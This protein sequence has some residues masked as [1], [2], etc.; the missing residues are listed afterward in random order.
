MANLALAALVALATVG[1]SH[2]IVPSTYYRTFSRAHPVLQ[3]VKPGDSIVHEDAR[4]RRGRR[5]GRHPERAVQPPERAVLRRGGRA[6]RR[7]GGQDHDAEDEPQ[8][9]LVG[10]PLGPVLAHARGRRERLFERSTS[11]T[12]SARGGRTLVPWDIDLAKQT[13]KLREP[14]SAKLPMEFPARPM[15]GCIGV[16]P[17]G[18]F[19]PTSGPSGAYGGN[20]DY[21]KIGQGATV[22]LPVYHPGALLFVG[23]GHALQAD[24]EPTGTGIETSM[25]VEFTVE[26]KKGAAPAGP[27]V[28]TARRPDL[29]R[30]AA[31]VRQRPRQRPQ[32]G[33]VRHGQVAHQGLRPRTLG[34]PP[35]HRLSGQVR[36]RDRRRL[37]GPAG[38]EGR[39]PRAEPLRPPS[40][41]SRR[42][43]PK[44]EPKPIAEKTAKL[45]KVDGFL[46]L[47]W[48]E[49]TGKVLMEIPRFDREFLYQVTLDDRRGLEPDRAR[50]GPARLDQGRRFPEGRA[51]GL[52][53]GAQLSLPR[54]QR[55]PRRA[56]V[57]RAVVREVGPLG[58]QGR[59]RGGRPGPGQRHRL[60]RPRRPRRRRPPDPDQA[61]QV[62]GGRLA[63]R[64][65][66]ARP[67]G[68][69]RR[70][71][72]SRRP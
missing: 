51:E 39:P 5:E 23:D 42:P 38:P 69:S 64:P 71:P 62:Q 6:W 66:P 29:D 48:D 32:D 34:R 37:D 65:G 11:P 28:E 41:R 50:P 46:P 56:E 35:P 55:Q 4:L 31:R 45:A 53:G 13:V 15:L 25:D 21:N 19:A 67:E 7:P 30:L 26:V 57:G 3:R 40:P 12:S 44:P 59:G 22:I 43:R 8:L 1:D 68:R 52:P 72:R 60:L 49:S 36:R 58:V 33:H 10:L 27:R 61:G 63:E 20:L 47:Y 24:G 54:P 18:D 17:P 14:K 70:T 9:G 2:S 16:A